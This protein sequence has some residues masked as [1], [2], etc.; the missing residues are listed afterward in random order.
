MTNID[1][2]LIYNVN[3]SVNLIDCRTFCI[4][5]IRFC[6]QNAA[7]LLIPSIFIRTNI[8]KSQNRIRSFEKT[9]QFW[10]LLWSVFIQWTKH[11]HI[12]EYQ[13]ITFFPLI[14]YSPWDNPSRL[15]AFRRNS[16]PSML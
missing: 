14:M 9:F 5:A 1:N 4:K 7:L 16:R 12:I 2:Y 6:S 11:L 8:I 3:I 13:R 15:I 10:D